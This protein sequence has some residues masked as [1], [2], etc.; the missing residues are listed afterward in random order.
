M[1]KI[2]EGQTINTPSIVGNE[3]DSGPSHKK[4][5]TGKINESES[6]YYTIKIK[7]LPD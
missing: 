2:I 4:T 6:I 1:V 3:P 5:N 7:I